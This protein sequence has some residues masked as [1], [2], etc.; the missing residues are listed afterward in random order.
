ME[1]P[2]LDAASATERLQL[3]A[4]QAAWVRG[5]ERAGPVRELRLPPLPEAPEVLRRLAVAPDDADE[6]LEGWPSEQWPAELVWLLERVVAVVRADMGGAEW[7]E[8]GPSLPGDRGLA[9]KHFYVYAGPNAAE[10]PVLSVTTAPSGLEG[11]GFPVRRAFAGVDLTTL[12]P[13]VH[14]DQMGEVDYAPGEPE[15]TPWHPHMDGHGID[16]I[17]GGTGDRKLEAPH[18]PGSC[19]CA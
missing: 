11:E 18:A 3:P 10:R 7:L 2:N 16:Q 6:I 15:G 4:E 14:M 5:L 17:R 13:F 12:D 9:W 1:S 19:P 8:P